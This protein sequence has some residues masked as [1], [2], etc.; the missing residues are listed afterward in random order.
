MSETNSDLQ[1]HLEYNCY[2]KN[3][4]SIDQSRV[5][6]LQNDTKEIYNI[7]SFF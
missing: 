5:N 7:N 6:L 3:T 2:L 4:F 1:K